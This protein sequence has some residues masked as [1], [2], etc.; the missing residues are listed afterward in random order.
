MQE[1]SEVKEGEGKQPRLKWSDVPGERE[2]EREAGRDKERAIFGWRREN[3]RRR[4][5]LWDGQRCWT[6]LR[7]LT[8]ICTFYDATTCQK[9]RPHAA[10]VMPPSLLAPPLTLL[11][12]FFSHS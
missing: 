2:R 6:G 3:E 1:G 9:T 12:P 11:V 8:M 5:G 10:L 4:A 7:C